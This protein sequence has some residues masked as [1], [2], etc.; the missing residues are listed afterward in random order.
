M[1]LWEDLCLLFFLLSQ[2]KVTVG[3]NCQSSNNIWPEMSLHLTIFVQKSL[4]NLYEQ[5]TLSFGM[6]LVPLLSSIF[7]DV[8]INHKGHG[9]RKETKLFSAY[10]LLFLGGFVLFP[11]SSSSWSANMEAF[12]LWGSLFSVSGRVHMIYQLSCCPFPPVA[13]VFLHLTADKW[14]KSR[15]ALSK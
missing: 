8:Q 1:I 11:Q 6:L 3:I 13:E 5:L 7:E 10:N 15:N 9:I 14:I 2:W 4:R 12:K